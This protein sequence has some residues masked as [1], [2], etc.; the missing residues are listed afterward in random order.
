M[1]SLS[2]KRGV[3]RRLV[4]RRVYD[5]KSFEFCE[6]KR[7]ANGLAIAGR[8]IAVAGENLPATVSYELLCAQDLSRCR[9]LH[10]ECVLAGET[11][12]LDLETAGEDRWRK[13]GAAAPELDGCSDLDLEWSPSTNTFP[14]RR[15]GVAATEPMAI[16]AAWVRLPGLAVEAVTQS[17]ERLG[18]T[19]VRYAV[20]ATGFEAEID[21]DD[22]G[23][24]ITYQRIWTRIAEWNP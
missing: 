11:S 22:L 20:K 14:I 8:I 5:D 23:L 6:V 9:S 13:N 19:R 4:W 17:Y 24:P 16:K 12:T 18:P 10:L 7:A 15:L 2:T 3:L 21:V 1:N